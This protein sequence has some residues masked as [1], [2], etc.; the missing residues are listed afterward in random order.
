[1]TKDL[2][3]LLERLE[4]ADPDSFQ[5]ITDIIERHAENT[6]KLNMILDAIPKFIAQQTGED[7][8]DAGEITPDILSCDTPDEVCDIINKWMVK[9]EKRRCNKRS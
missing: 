9:N 3:E 6:E 5:D 4:K 1:M 8:S 7:E 2:K